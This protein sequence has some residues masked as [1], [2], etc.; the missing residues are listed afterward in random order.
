MQVI[1]NGKAYKAIIVE[2]NNGCKGCCAD[3]RVQLCMDLPTCSSEFICKHS[4][5]EMKE[6]AGYKSVVFQPLNG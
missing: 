3:R 6:F 2:V 4:S 5:L 1:V